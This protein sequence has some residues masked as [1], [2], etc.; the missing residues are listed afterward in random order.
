MQNQSH[1]AG[2]ARIWLSWGIN[3][4]LAASSSISRYARFGKLKE[5]L[6]QR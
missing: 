4:L 3:T 6:Q 2:A 1:L 5:R